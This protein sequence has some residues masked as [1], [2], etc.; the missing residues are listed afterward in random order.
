MVY[1]AALLRMGLVIPASQP[2]GWAAYPIAAYPVEMSLDGQ[3]FTADKQLYTYYPSP[4]VVPR[5]DKGSH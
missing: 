3:T 1:S 4:Q 2:A 5:L